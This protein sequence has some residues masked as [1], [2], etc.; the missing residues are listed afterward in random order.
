MTLY[1]TSESGLV[2][3]TALDA[4]ESE[5]LAR[6]LL[7]GRGGELGGE[8]LL[9]LT[10]TV[11]EGAT[12]ALAVDAEGA[13]VVI[14]A[15]DGEVE[16]AAVTA[17]LHDASDAATRGYDSLNDAFA[18]DASLREAHAEYFDREPLDP[19]AFNP[20]QRVRLLGPG[21]EAAALDLAAF[22]S[23]KELAV[24]PVR[25]DAF[26]SDE[27]FLVRF[28]TPDK[29]PTRSATDGVDAAGVDADGGTD[30]A[31][32]AR[33][34]VSKTGEDGEQAGAG[35]PD[36]T[37]SDAERNGIASNQGDT[38]ES[39]GSE[40]GSESATAE[41]PVGGA[42]PAD[43]SG[44]DNEA[45][46]HADG[47]ALDLPA[48]LETVAE[49]VRTR[50]AGTFQ[51]DVAELVSIE[52]GNELLVRPDHSAYAGGVLRYRLVPGT[53][54]GV[55]FEVNIYGGSEAEKEQ[56]R[57]VVRRNEAAI[58]DEFGYSVA[59]RYDGF[60]GHREFDRLDDDAASAIVD[61]FDRLV[62]FFH[63]LVMQSWR[64]SR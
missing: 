35:D 4:A 44:T 52:P 28:G 64:E 50:L 46:E 31:G 54:G 29:S 58:E 24:T 20:D 23:R 26:S 59:D 2:A 51:G 57:V 48:L 3:V 21:F 10:R 18:G 49:G 39:A 55:G 1:R 60:R 12:T 25:V 36:E 22:L 32:S 38:T 40:S 9:F 56:M 63:P 11:G 45:A 16:R 37:S 30:A 43:S 61:E 62:R 42:E 34:V 19:E 33:R 47:E 17:A 53:D 15:V 7:R 14:R 5:G 8:D 41:Q 6:A 27:E 13:V